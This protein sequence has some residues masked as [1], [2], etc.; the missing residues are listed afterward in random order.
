[1]AKTSQ[2]DVPDAF[3]HPLIAWVYSQSPPKQIKKV[4]GDIGIS[5]VALC[6]WDN[7]RTRPSGHVLSRIIEYTGGAVTPDACH[8]YWLSKQ[9]HAA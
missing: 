2:K 3:R 6:R 7:G 1:M 8:A 9:K 5:R 4:C